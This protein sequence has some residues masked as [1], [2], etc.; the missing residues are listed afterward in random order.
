MKQ[1][2]EVRSTSSVKKASCARALELGGFELLI[3]GVARQSVRLI[4]H[5]ATFAGRSRLS[6]LT[7]QMFGWMVTALREECDLNHGVIQSM[8]ALPRSTYFD[9]LS[10]RS[11]SGHGVNLWL[12]ILLQ[13]QRRAPA[14][15]SVEEL[16]QI[17]PRVDEHSLRGILAD[18]Q[19]QELIA[20]ATGGASNLAWE[21]F[22][23]V[24]AERVKTVI[25]CA[26][27]DISSMLLVAVYQNGPIGV[28]ALAERLGLAVA[29]IEDGLLDLND[30]GLIDVDR[31]N[32]AERWDCKGLD[33]A[34][35]NVEAWHAAVYDHVH[36]VVNAVIGKLRSEKTQA[37]MED[38]VGGSTFSYEVWPGHPHEKRVGALFKKVRAEGNQ[39]LEELRVFEQS[40]AAKAKPPAAQRRKVVF[41][42]G[43]AVHHQDE[44]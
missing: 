43:Q 15:L 36:A 9:R 29:E 20:C 32:G 10:R 7:E 34:F 40:E 42:C 35:E 44:S 30:R 33:I 28:S 19:K 8:L 4:A 11:E 37:C 5:I 24:D 41:Y 18:L 16:A 25:D 22:A 14:P 23:I 39:L 1:L 27:E 31:S 6:G 13:F 2:K 21:R 3:D 12:A 38:E 17:L 26:L